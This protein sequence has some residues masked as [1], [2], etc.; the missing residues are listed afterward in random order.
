[1]SR[2]R[3][4]E[5]ES[6]GGFGAAST[7]TGRG[8]A[9][10]KAVIT[11]G[12]LAQQEQQAG[13]QQSRETLSRQSVHALAT[14]A[15]DSRQARA[16]SSTVKRAEGRRSIGMILHKG[17]PVARRGRSILYF[18]LRYGRIKTEGS[19]HLQEDQHVDRSNTLYHS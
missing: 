4:D 12:V 13:G 9:Q 7:G 3:K 18:P 15:R 5:Y 17:G 19:L 10:S 11:D 14:G 8:A 1:M 2:G 6:P 16:T